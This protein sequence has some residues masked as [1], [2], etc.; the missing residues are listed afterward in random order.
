MVAVDT[1]I[2]VRLIVADDETQLQRALA[3]AATEPMYVS[4]TV[5]VETD[6]VLRS[7][8]GY[9]RG[10]IVVAIASLYQAFDIVF[11]NPADVRWALE[12]YALAGE[13]A[14]YLHI[15]AARPA[16]RFASFE[17]RLVSRAGDEPPVA[18]EGLN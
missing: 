8:Y 17:R 1:N 16:G 11:E 18:V 6:W 15:S 4:L 13:F 7:V 9:D 14:D 10:R 2:I 3:L 12:R 5:L